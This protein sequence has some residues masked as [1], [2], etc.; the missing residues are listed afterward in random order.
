MKIV[1]QLL[2]GKYFSKKLKLFCKGTQKISKLFQTFKK[3]S[4]RQSTKSLFWQTFCP[5]LGQFLVSKGKIYLILVKF[6][7]KVDFLTEFVTTSQKFSEKYLKFQKLFRKQSYCILRNI[8]PWSLVNQNQC[9]Y[10]ISNT[11]F[12]RYPKFCIC[13]PILVAKSCI[14]IT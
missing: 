4:G 8:Y 5:F 3:N 1:V 14:S 2:R 10:T 11:D 6:H 9:Y 12:S 13:L 7:I